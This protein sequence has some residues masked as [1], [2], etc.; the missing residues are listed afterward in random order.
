MRMPTAQSPLGRAIRLP[1]QL[2]PRER[3]LP[4]LAGPLRG[5]RWI[6]GSSVH[7]CWLGTFER[8]EQRLFECILR[9]GQTVYDLG[10]NVGFYTL[11]AARLVGSSGRVLAF[12][13]A[14]RNLAYLRQHVAL[15]GC[16]NVEVIEAAVSD[17][18][19]SAVFEI[20]ASNAEGRLVRDRVVDHGSWT[21]PLV[22]IDGLANAGRIPLPH[23]IKIDVEGE[24]SAVLDGALQTLQRAR[25]RVLL[26]THSSDLRAR[27]VSQL[28]QLG[29]SV[30]CMADDGGHA[31]ELDCIPT[32][33]TRSSP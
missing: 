21:V 30:R 15:N 24:E 8:Y 16:H 6:P 23:L 27:C 12:E 10:A 4:I 31:T 5:W 32:D 25:P 33:D 26:S 20:G 28:T 19:G 11:L 13:P 3:P 17:H 22:T 9:P 2:V 7:G 18:A 1:L 14:S 29:Y